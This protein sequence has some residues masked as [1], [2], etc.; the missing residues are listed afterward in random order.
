MAEEEGFEPSRPFRVQ[1]FSRP[2]HSTTLPLLHIDST[3]YWKPVAQSV[4]DFKDAPWSERRKRQSTA[5]S[6][7]CGLSL[8]PGVGNPVR[9]HSAPLSVFVD[10][11][12]FRQEKAEKGF[13]LEAASLRNR[14]DTEV[15]AGAFLTQRA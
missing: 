13:S 5:V 6:P 12:R 7:E 1:R 4:K 10:V 9:M 2:S 8:S 3:T 14:K 11:C 15:V